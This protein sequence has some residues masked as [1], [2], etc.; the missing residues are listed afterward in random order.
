MILYLRLLLLAFR[1]AAASV[2]QTCIDV[3]LQQQELKLH[4][5]GD[6]A[7]DTACCACTCI[8]PGNIHT[9]CGT[10]RLSHTRGLHHQ[11]TGRKEEDWNKMV[12]KHS[13]GSTR[14]FV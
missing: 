11:R 9:A 10:Y 13:M 4:I 14:Y 3:N 1:E 5:Y 6:T 2:R 12:N 7:G 8:I